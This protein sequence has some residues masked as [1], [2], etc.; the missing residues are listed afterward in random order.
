MNIISWNCRGAGSKTFPSII[1][2]L[3]QEYRANLFFLLE[4]HINGTR[5]KQIRDKMGFDKSFVVDV[6]GHAG[7]IWCLCD[8]SVWRVDVLEHD[9]QF[10]HLKVS[11]S[12]NNSTPWLVTAVYVKV[13]TRSFKN[14]SESVAWLIWVILVGRSLGREAG[15]GLSNLDWQIA[16]PEACVKH[17]PMLKLGHSPICLQLSNTMTQNRGRQ[18]FLFLL[19]GSPT[20]ILEILWMS[21]RMFKCLGLRVFLCLR[22]NLN[23]GTTCSDNNIIGQ[24]VINEEVKYAIFGMDSWKAPNRDGLQAIFYQS[25]WNKVGTN[26]YNVKRNCIWRIGDGSQI[27]FWDHCW[28][29]T[30][31][32]C[33]SKIASQ[34]SNNVNYSDMLMDFLNV[35]GQWHIEKLQ[36]MLPEDTIKKIEHMA[37]TY[38]PDDSNLFFNTDLNDWLLLNPTSHN[39]CSCLFGVVV[40]SLWYF[41]NKLVLNEE[42]VPNTSVVHQIQARVEEFLKVVKS[43]LN[44]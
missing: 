42:T 35:S 31:V 29:P 10:I 14:V 39:N 36:E 1:R 30:G 24:N 27:H 37:N 11:G 4:T 19:P 44:P 41:R 16:F 8:S 3:H 9:R 22:A 17:L 25:Q 6:V 26:V 13:P 20:Q 40:S 12:G 7:G 38:P 28:I 2:D 33:L 5:G 34:V 21:L 23:I 32:G 43:K 15:Q 18:P